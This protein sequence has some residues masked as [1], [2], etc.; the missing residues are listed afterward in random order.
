MTLVD[1]VNKV[2]DLATICLNKEDHDGYRMCMEL[3]AD[4]IYNECV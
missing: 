3:I 2:M 1:F 4:T